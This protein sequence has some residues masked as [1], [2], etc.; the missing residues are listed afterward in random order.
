MKNNSTTGCFTAISTDADTY[1]VAGTRE[2]VPVA[3]LQKNACKSAHFERH[4]H[5]LVLD[6]EACWQEMKLVDTTIDKSKKV[7]LQHVQKFLLPF[8]I[9]G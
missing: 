9:P 6:T 2:T 7:K 5:R 4:D 1:I 8:H 3:L